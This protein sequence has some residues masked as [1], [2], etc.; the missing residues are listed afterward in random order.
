M[1]IG[2]EGGAD[3]ADALRTLTTEIEDVREEEPYQ[4]RVRLRTSH[5]A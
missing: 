5:E 3:L 4:L 1:R 2:Y